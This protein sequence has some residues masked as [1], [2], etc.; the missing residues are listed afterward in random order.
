MKI[1]CCLA[2]YKNH[3]NYGT[4]LQGYATVKVLQSLGHEVRI[5]KYNKNDSLLRKVSVAPLQ[6]ISGGWAAFLRRSK[7]KRLAND[8]SE[9]SMNIQLRTE[10]NNRFKDEAMEPFCDV[11][12]GYDKLKKG[13][14]NYDAVLVGSDQVW[15]PLGLYSNFFNLMFVEDSVRKISYASSFGVG[16]IPSWQRKATGKYL[17]RINHLSVRE[18]KAKEIVDSLSHK[19]AQVVCDPTLL[20][21]RTDWASDIDG[22][23]PKANGK[24]ILCYLLGGGIA[25][26]FVIKEFAEAKNIKI[27]ALRHVDEY[28]ECDET[29]GDECPYDVNPLEFIQLI[30]NAEYVFTDSFHCS[31]FSILF[32]KQFVTFYRFN[33][34]SKNSR[35][36]RIDSLFELFGLKDRLYNGNLIDQADC[37]IDYDNV[38]RKVERLRQESLNFLKQALK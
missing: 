21:T 5:I 7:K 2:Y 17:D 20:R 13:S 4:S 30:K 29:F 18:L 15:T 35:N 36:S 24:Y 38:N 34:T 12:I 26:R 1:G 32:N 16:V 37:A 33:N 3:N 22:L 10:A 14:L 25:S 19:K 11:Y 6:L 9:Y 27:V 23:S 8:N 28:L 31:V